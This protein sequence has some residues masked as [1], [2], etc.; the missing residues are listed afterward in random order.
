MSV[1]TLQTN[2]KYYHLK[3]SPR[4]LKIQIIWMSLFHVPNEF[5][6]EKMLNFKMPKGQGLALFQVSREHC[7]GHCRLAS[8]GYLAEKM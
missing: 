7:P 5:K 4:N 1:S 3:K 2:T 6:A 8:L